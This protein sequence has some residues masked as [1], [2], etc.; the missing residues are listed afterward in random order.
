MRFRKLRIA[1]SATCLIACVLLI[2]LW[3]RSYWW[4]DMLFSQ[5]GNDEVGV[6]S[7]CG[8]IS[9]IKFLSSNDA[10]VALPRRFSVGSVVV[11]D[12]DRARLP[13]TFLGFGYSRWIKRWSSHGRELCI[14]HWF[15]LAFLATFA[16]SPWIQCSN[17]FSLRT[18][19][20]ATT[21]V[22]VVLGLIVWLSR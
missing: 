12:V 11:D 2:S 13:E 1:F 7:I 9:L 18:L 8:E 16:V 17:R 3:V 4:V 20:I 10:Q 5:G 19:L 14:P 6:E 21:L 15:A 22:A